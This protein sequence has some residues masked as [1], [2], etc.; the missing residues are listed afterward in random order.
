MACQVALEYLSGWFWMDVLA[1]LPLDWIL[2]DH[3][4]AHSA[5][6]ELLGLDGPNSQKLVRKVPAARCGPPHQS[7]YACPPSGHDVV[8]AD[9]SYGPSSGNFWRCSSCCGCAGWPC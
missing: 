5:I 4:G 8:A 2:Q 6:V 1:I 7:A 9:C 3:D